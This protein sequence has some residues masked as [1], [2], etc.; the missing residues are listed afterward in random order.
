[1]EKVMLIT[2]LSMVIWYIIDRFKP[3]WE[4]VKNGKYIT[5]LVSAIMSFGVTFGF[6]LDIVSALEFFPDNMVV[7]NI[8]T[9]L[10]LMSG[11]SAVSEIIGNI[12]KP[13]APPIEI[14]NPEEVTVS[15]AA[16][17][18]TYLSHP[19]EDNEACEL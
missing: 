7:G 8:L 1:M 17:G 10:L 12:K 15:P 19:D 5:V 2:F 18:M 13:T 11:S 4:C 9:G 14:T 16:M 3:L 6:S